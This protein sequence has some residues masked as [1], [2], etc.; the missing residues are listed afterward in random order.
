MWSRLCSA[1][2]RLIGAA[3]AFALVSMAGAAAP[4]IAQEGFSEDLGIIRACASDVWRLC[5]DVLPDVLRIKSCV[6]DKM[7][8]LSKGC[9]DKLLD[10]MA[11]SS[12]KVCKDQTYALCAAARCNVFDGVA[13]CQCDVKHGDSISLPFRMGEGEDGC[14]INAAGS[15]NKYMVST[16]SLPES[17]ASP[18]GGGAVYTCQG[19]DGG[20]YAQ[21]DGGLCFRSTEKTTFPGFDKPVPKGQI[22]CSCP[23]TKST[24][25]NAQSYQIL[26]PYPCDKSFFK[27]C[28][29]GTANGKTGSTIYVGAPAGTAAALAVQL[30]GKVPP[31]NECSPPGG[32]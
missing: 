9:L 12:F 1:K 18:Q 27:Y 20:A 7:G 26:G 24:A 14:S 2:A 30:N 25:A 21:C 19:E 17:I 5:S 6:Q 28:K 23:I 15:A 32:N 31:L 10:A 3:F 11:G 13:Y 16:Y 29:G 4:A 8:Q 22:I